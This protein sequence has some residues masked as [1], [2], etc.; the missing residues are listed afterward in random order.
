MLETSD[1]VVLIDTP[2]D[3]RQQVLA[4]DIRRVD[5]VL[6]THAHADHVLGL[7]DLRAFNRIQRAAIPCFGSASTLAEIESMFH[8]VFESGEVRVGKPR[9]ELRPVSGRFMVSALPVTAI[10]LWHGEQ[11]IFGYRVGAFAYL[12]D[13]SRIPD[14]SFAALE[15]LEL[16][17]LDALRYRRHATHFSVGEAIATAARIGARRTLLT[18]MTHAIDYAR[19]EVP[20]PASVEFAY[21]GLVVEL[22]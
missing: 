2:T 21:D 5:A 13:C 15:G 19:P 22:P 16:L 11:E 20:M 18:H 4:N 8:Y 10:P 7:D 3:L 12:T 1:Q 17:V 9:L 6:Y 14:S